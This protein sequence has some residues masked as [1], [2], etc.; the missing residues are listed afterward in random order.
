MLEVSWD[1]GERGR[2]NEAKFNYSICFFHWLF[3]I[4]KLVLRNKRFTDFLFQKG[5]NENKMIH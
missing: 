2:Q 3:Q 1:G 4:F 5:I